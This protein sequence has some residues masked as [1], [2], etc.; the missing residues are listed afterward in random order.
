MRGVMTTAPLIQDEAAAD[1]MS[2]PG[3]ASGQEMTSDGA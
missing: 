1:P 3:P 2:P